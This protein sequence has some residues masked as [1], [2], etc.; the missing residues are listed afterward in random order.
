MCSLRGAAACVIL[1]L[2]V[3]AAIALSI[4]TGLPGEHVVHFGIGAGM[5][6]LAAAAFDLGG[7]RWLAWFGALTAGAFGTIFVLQGTADVVGDA[8]LHQLAFQVL[9]QQVERVLPELILGWAVA[10]LLL[11]STGRTKAF[12]AIVLAITVGAEVV[13]VVGPAI[14]IAVPDVKLRWLLPFVWLLAEFAKPAGA[15]RAVDATPAR[16][17]LAG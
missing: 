10:V 12:G 11:A 1:L 13:T 14:G 7:P 2:T 17:A 4:A 8:T 16:R 5:L 6:L 15:P 3:P 9:G